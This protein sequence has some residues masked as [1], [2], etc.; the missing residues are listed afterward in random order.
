MAQDQSLNKDQVLELNFVPTWARKP[1]EANPYGAFEE[2]ESE[3]R[4]RR[5]PRGRERRGDDRDRRPRRDMG[6]R[7]RTAR[8]PEQDLGHEPGR[9]AERSRPSFSRPSQPPPRAPVDVAFIPDRDRLAALIKQLRSYNKAFPLMDMAARFLANP[10]AHLVKFA[11]REPVEGETPPRLF[12]CKACRQ[13]FMRREA[14][15]QH[16]GGAHLDLFF[17]REELQVDPPSGAFSC[18]ARCRLSGVLLGPP[19]YHTYAE[20]LNDLWRERFAHMTLDEYRNH[21]ETLK[22]EALI[23]QWKAE[24]TVRVVYRDI[25]KPEGEPMTRAE[26]EALMAKQYMPTLVEEGARVIVPAQ[27]TRAFVDRGLMQA[28]REAWQKESRFPLSLA[29]ALRPALR[30]MGMSFF[31]IQDGQT[32]V[33]PIRPNPADPEKFIDDIREVLNYL[34]DHPGCTRRE[35]VEALAPGDDPA[36]AAQRLEP[37]RWLIDRGHVIEFFDGRI[38][39]PAQGSRG[40]ARRKPA[41]ASDA[42]PT[43]RPP[44]DD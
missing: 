30:H 29:I 8:R 23:E 17:R 35:L 31:K 3:G 2:R 44:A 33:T 41:D 39:V 11:V 38:S 5:P 4:S 24:Q 37:L 32:F 36:A 1:P 27:V 25:Q 15:M 14:L 34:S 40:G 18:V 20:K 7:T 26:A 12:A 22:D 10:D 16:I 19:N 13:V 9:P 28:V 43:E 42:Q 6:D 21:I